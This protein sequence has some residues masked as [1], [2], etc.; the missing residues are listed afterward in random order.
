MLFTFK[1]DDDG[2]ERIYV[3]DVCVA[4]LRHGAGEAYPVTVVPGVDGDHIADAIER[5]DEAG[6]WMGKV[7]GVDDEGTVYRSASRYE[8]AE[9]SVDVPVSDSTVLSVTTE[10]SRDQLRIQEG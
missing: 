5:A 6:F 9:I 10:A 1:R 7:V 2:R 4:E 8:T 3:G